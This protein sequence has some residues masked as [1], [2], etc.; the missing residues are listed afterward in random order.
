MRERLR[1][2]RWSASTS[3]FWGPKKSLRVSPL[4]LH[5]PCPNMGRFKASEALKHVIYSRPSA[6]ST[7]IPSSGSISLSAA[8]SSGVVGLVCD[9]CSSPGGSWR[10]DVQRRFFAGLPIIFAGFLS[11]VCYLAAVALASYCLSSELHLVYCLVLKETGT[12]YRGLSPHKITPIVGRT[13]TEHGMGRLQ[14]DNQTA[15]PGDVGRS[16]S[17]SQVSA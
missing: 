15:V 6:T 16:A 12:K 14:M 5:T 7:S 8:S 10:A 17:R 9:F 11:T 1:R 13:A 3:S 4:G 2:D